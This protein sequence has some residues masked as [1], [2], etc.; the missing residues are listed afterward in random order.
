MG[1]GIMKSTFVQIASVRYEPHTD[2]FRLRSYVGLDRE[3]ALDCV[4]FD[5]CITWVFVS[6]SCPYTSVKSKCLYS[7]HEYPYPLNK[8]GSTELSGGCYK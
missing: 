4:E 7:G 5:A 6:S 3:G 8:Y 2:H 1:V